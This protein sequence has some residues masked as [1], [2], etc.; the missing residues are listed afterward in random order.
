VFNAFRAAL[1]HR[2][3]DQ[4]PFEA[5]QNAFDVAVRTYSERNPDVPEERARRAVANII[6]R[7]LQSG[8]EQTVIRSKTP[9]TRED[10]TNENVL[11]LLSAIKERVFYV[12][13]LSGV[14]VIELAWLSIMV[15]IFVKFWRYILP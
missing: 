13:T 10:A 3:A 2:R 12:F 6:C 15:I 4:I 11:E 8:L 5:D 9:L 14:I 1:R 7:K